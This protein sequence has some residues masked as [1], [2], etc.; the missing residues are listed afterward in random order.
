MAA[1]LQVTEYLKEGS[2]YS[3]HGESC[4]IPIHLAVTFEAIGGKGKRGNGSRPQPEWSFAKV[5]T[6]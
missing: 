4:E 3:T 2:F 5:R 6:T 1:Y